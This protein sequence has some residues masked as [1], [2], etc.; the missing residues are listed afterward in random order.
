MNMDR[1]KACMI[2]LFEQAVDR[3]HAYI[4]QQ[5]L[6]DQCQPTFRG[7]SMQTGTTALDHLIEAGDLVEGRWPRLR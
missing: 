1:A 3:G 2:H 4:E 7:H 5:R 6:F